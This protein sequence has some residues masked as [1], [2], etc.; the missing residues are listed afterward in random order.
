MQS[1]FRGVWFG[2]F[3]VLIVSCC[4]CQ[5]RTTTSI[6]DEPSKHDFG[7]AGKWVLEDEKRPHLTQYFEIE[8]GDDG[9][10]QLRPDR[11]K[12]NPATW[13]FRVCETDVPEIALIEWIHDAP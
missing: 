12:E 5:F 13:S 2:L 3:S 6:I 10:Y 7:F 8:M 1:R 11:I 4:A 9:T